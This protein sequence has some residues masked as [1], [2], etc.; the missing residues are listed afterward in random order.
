MG[1][2]GETT[3]GGGPGG[4]PMNDEQR[5]LE[6]AQ[7]AQEAQEKERRIN[8][9]VAKLSRAKDK[10]YHLVEILDVKKSSATTVQWKYKGYTAWGGPAR[11]RAHIL[12]L[13]G[14]GV[15]AAT[16]PDEEDTNVCLEIETD[17]ANKAEREVR[18]SAALAAAKAA[19]SARK[20]KDLHQSFGDYSTRQIDEQ[21]GKAFYNNGIPFKV[22]D[23][24][25]FRKA[26]QMTSQ[27]L[28]PKSMKGDNKPMYINPNRN[29][30]GGSLLVAMDASIQH[31][32]VEM[33]A[34]DLR[35][36]G[37]TY[38][39]DGCSSLPGSRPL[40]NGLLETPSA[41]RFL[42]A[43]DATGKTK[44]AQ[45]IYDVMQSDLDTFLGDDKEFVDF[46]CMD[47][48]ELSVLTKIEAENPKMSAAICAPHSISNLAKDLAKVDFIKEVIDEVHEAVLFFKAHQKS[49]ALWEK[50]GGKSL[51]L[52]PD[53]R[54]V[55]NFIMV[56]ALKADKACARKTVVD[57][58]YDPWL[59]DKGYKAL[60]KTVASRMLS[61]SFW[62]KL[63]LVCKI[64]EPLVRTCK[65]FDSATPIM[66]H[67]HGSMLE[68]Q[69][70][71][72]NAGLSATRLKVVQKTIKER[73]EYF[74]SAYH[75]AGFV[76]NP[77]FIDMEHISNASNMRYTRTVIGRLFHDAPEKATAARRQLTI[78][79][80]KEGTFALPEIWDDAKEMADYR[81]WQ[82]YGADVPELQFVALHVLSKRGSA[83]SAERN[84]S[85]FDFIW[86]KKRNRL[87]AAKATMLVRVHSNLRLI[88]KRSRSVFD[89]TNAELCAREDS[90][91]GSSD[92]EE[93]ASA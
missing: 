32:V 15:A 44:T 30:I 12:G 59:A 80:N 84:W 23:D 46:V 39:G 20:Q 45:Y 70:A 68:L 47:G 40:I 17:L 93:G 67:I 52:P 35:T 58:A 71:V 5:E 33:T 61:E 27:S 63:D 54:F 31:K 21:W 55:Y 18:R 60:G 86:T 75:G 2:N 38:V 64:A 4:A 77:G 51:K 36:F 85:E 73:W 48:G 10:E 6:T 65:K 37:A 1:D 22:A 89:D 57:D 69:V 72:D 88:G 3:T 92:D 29:K 43:T 91:D 66:G 26:V 19:D 42:H 25:E 76:L 41:T 79:L 83:S 78:F 62:Q 82:L 50:H 7:E 81:W 14:K 87:K 53:T 74:H 13:R 90:D 28:Q 49:R 34:A 56:L 11:I 8:E 24:P 16:D 9:F